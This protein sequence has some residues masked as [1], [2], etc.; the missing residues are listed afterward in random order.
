MAYSSGSLANIQ[1]SWKA[2]LNTIATVPPDS[3][4]MMFSKHP[5]LLKREY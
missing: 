3:V 2:S 5:N 4:A 1:I